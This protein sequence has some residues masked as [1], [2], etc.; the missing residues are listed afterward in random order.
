MKINHLYK[1]LLA[2]IIV[3]VLFMASESV[4]VST[5]KTAPVIEYGVYSMPVKLYTLNGRAI[6]FPA[7]TA[8]ISCEQVINPENNSSFSY[9]PNELVDPDPTFCYNLFSDGFD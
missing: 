4:A 8:Y 6:D 9:I 5:Q 7:G 1:L 3:V 2:A